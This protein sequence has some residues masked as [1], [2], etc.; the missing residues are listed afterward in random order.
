MAENGVQ[1]DV[2]VI[3]IG[4]NTVRLVHFR[5]E[6]R[7]LW[8]VYNEKVMAGLGNGVAETG[9]LNPEG[10]IVAKRALKRFQRLLDTNH[11]SE[12]HLVATAAVRNAEDG[13]SFVADIAAICGFEIQ[14]LS[15][16]DEGDLSAAGLICGIPNAHGVM[17][18]LGGS[19]LE[20]ARIEMG[21]PATAQTFALGPQEALRGATLNSTEM[22]AVIDGAL[23]TA[24]SLQPGGGDFY[25][26]GGAWRAL[27]QLA[28]TRLGYPLH[29]VHQFR[30]DREQVLK[31]TGFVAEADLAS[32]AAIDGVPSRRAGSLPFAALLLQRLI[33]LGHCDGVV[34]SAYGLREGVL[35]RSV[36]PILRQA[37]PMI[38][39]SEAM[40]RPVSPVSGFG[41][42]VAQWI[43]PSLASLEPVFDAGRDTDLH[44]AASRLIDLGA[45]MHPDHRVGLVRNSVLYSPIA[46]ASHVERAFLAAISHYRYGGGERALMKRPAF[47]MLDDAQML[48]ARF[49]GVILRLAAKL[50]GRSCALLDR[51]DLQ[52][53]DACLC[54]EVDEQVRDL[55]VERSASLVKSAA[56]LIGHKSEV[57]YR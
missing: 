10:V 21:V 40:A 29:V 52:I 50:S 46:N 11:I 42:A 24:E 2:A 23:E 3:D 1:R 33:E 44:E 19:S 14:I 4:S 38:A 57:R 5:L 25:A 43:A 13:V 45:R 37:D 32:L 39:G 18:D 17:G 34:F 47:G 56:E 28:F 41:R 31:L 12:R 27:A 7:A 48:R 51:F 9:K 49:I 8:P 55:Y 16:E 22:V 6:G 20:L 30:L 53:K 36:P 15:G 35:M 54:L 26:I